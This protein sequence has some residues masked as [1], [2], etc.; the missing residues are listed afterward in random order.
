MPVVTPLEEVRLVAD[1]S[2]G[3]TG[4]DAAAGTAGAYVDPASARAAVSRG[5]FLSGVRLGGGGRSGPGAAAS[6]GRFLSGVTLG[7][8]GLI[9]AAVAVPVIGFALGPSFSGEDWY[10]TDLGP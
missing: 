2:G 4:H 5:R 6:P 8:G 10:W 7:V 1:P 9:G 3:H